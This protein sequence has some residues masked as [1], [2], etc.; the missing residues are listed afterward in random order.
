[1]NSFSEIKAKF[2]KKKTGNTRKQT[3]LM[4]FDTG[5][6]SIL[7]IFLAPPSSFIRVNQSRGETSQRPSDSGSTK[8]RKVEVGPLSNVISSV[9]EY[10]IE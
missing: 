7:R 8:T 1:M 5:P 4:T 2:Y 3:E 9:Y 6:T 10:A